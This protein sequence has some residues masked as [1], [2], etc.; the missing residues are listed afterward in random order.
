MNN[1]LKVTFEV[2]YN[3]EMKSQTVIIDK[4]LLTEFDDSFIKDIGIGITPINELLKICQKIFVY[5][6]TK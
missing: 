5:E 3:G 6:Q 1:D 4:E 2:E